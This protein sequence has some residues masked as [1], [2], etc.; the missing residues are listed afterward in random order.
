MTGKSVQ[1]TNGIATTSIRY[2]V[3]QLDGESE[4]LI[5]MMIN[6]N[7]VNMPLIV[8]HKANVVRGPQSYLSV[9][10]MNDAM[11]KSGRQY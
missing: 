9:Q 5:P 4:E 11:R 8:N 6:D 1:N 10:E 3:M 2:R 7:G